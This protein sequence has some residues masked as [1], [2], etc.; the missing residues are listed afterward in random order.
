MLE[1][2]VW[3]LHKMNFHD[4]I[5]VKNKY[6]FLLRNNYDYNEHKYAGQNRSGSVSAINS[7][8]NSNAENCSGHRKQI[9]TNEKSSLRSADSC[10]K[11][12]RN[13]LQNNHSEATT[14]NSKSNSY[15]AG[16]NNSTLECVNKKK[17]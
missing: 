4:P 3:T 5:F 6:G 13:S 17:F 2:T 16:P 7:R 12:L 10:K 14:V 9:S 8:Y 1:I 11:Y 15:Y